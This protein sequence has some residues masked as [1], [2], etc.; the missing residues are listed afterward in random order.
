[1]TVMPRPPRS[2][3]PARPG[4]VRALLVAEYAFRPGAEVNPLIEEI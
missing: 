3:A 4:P 2:F 1:M